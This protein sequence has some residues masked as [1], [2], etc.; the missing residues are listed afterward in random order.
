LLLDN[1]ILNFLKIKLQN[2]CILW[3]F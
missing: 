2:I 1:Y 3:S